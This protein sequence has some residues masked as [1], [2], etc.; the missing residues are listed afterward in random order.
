MHPVENERKRRENGGTTMKSI[1]VFCGSSEGASSIYKE[2]AEQLGHELAKRQITLV[3]GGAKVGLMGAVADAVLEQGG[4]V[5]GVLP[6]F[7]QQREIAHPGLTKLILVDSMHERKAKMAELADGFIALPGGPGTMEEFFEVFTWAQLGL[8]GKPCGF[9][10]INHYYDPLL[11][12][13]DVM[14]REQF[15]Q[16]KY[17]AMIIT[18]STPEGLL[19]KFASYSAPPVKTYLN[20]QRT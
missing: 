18:D 16:P 9:L 14:L 13:F 10:N 7:L 12:M 20:E 11:S 15:M 5:I 17:H 6:H 4:Q 8:H 19:Q 1:A 3:Y 2:C